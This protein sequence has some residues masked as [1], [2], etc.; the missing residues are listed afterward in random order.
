MS[1]RYVQIQYIGNALSLPELE[2]DVTLIVTR[3]GKRFVPERTAWKVKA[4]E[5]TPY[6]G[7][8]EFLVCSECDGWLA[9]EDCTDPADGP[10][11]CENCG[12]R[13]L[14]TLRCGKCGEVMWSDGGGGYA[15]CTC[16]AEFGSDGE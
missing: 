14:G 16:G 13:I 10:S 11:W 8:F 1:L 12:A 15:S 9:G 2:R 5:P 3:D 4:E 7:S 6:G